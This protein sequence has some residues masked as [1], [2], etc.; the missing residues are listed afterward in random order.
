MVVHD[1]PT[2]PIPRKG[3]AVA[4]SQ[5]LQAITPME[6]LMDLLHEV[7]QLSRH[8]QR[9]ARQAERGMDN[10]AYAE[11]LREMLGDRMRWGDARMRILCYAS[12]AELGVSV[13][14]PAEHCRQAMT[15]GLGFPLR[16]LFWAAHRRMLGVQRTHW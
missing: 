6:R 11:V 16:V 13:E 10:L 1:F 2:T 3:M 9:S 7:R 14:L 12:A 4:A 15:G 5:T 8:I